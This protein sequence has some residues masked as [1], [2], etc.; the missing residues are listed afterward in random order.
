MK[1]DNILV[2]ENP[3]DKP[4]L[5]TGHKMYLI[6]SQDGL[7]PKRGAHIPHEMW[8]MWMPPAKFM[9]GFHI[10]VNGTYLDHADQFKMYP[11]GCEM[12]YQLAD[13]LIMR[14]FQWIP[15]EEKAFILELQ[16]ENTDCKDFAL[17]LDLKMITN[18]MPT[19][20]SDRMNIEAGENGI[21]VD[22][23]KNLL[24]FTTEKQSWTMCVGI[25]AE[26]SKVTCIDHHTCIASAALQVPAKGQVKMEVIFAAS[27]NSREEAEAT[28]CKVKDTKESL[29]AEKVAIYTE[30]GKKAALTYPAEP[31]LQEM[32]HWNQYIN[33]WIIR[34][35]DG[36]GAGVV[37][38]YPEFTWW[39]GNDTDYIVPALLM[40]GNY[41]IGKETLRL[42]RKKSEEINGNGRVVHEISNNGQVY[43]E[44]MSTETP[45]FADTVWMIYTWSGDVDFLT[46]MYDFCVQ[47]MEYIESI[48]VDGL[49][50]GYGIS[51]IAGLD[52]Y[53]CDCALLAVRGYEIL[54][55]MSQALGKTEAA[56]E[57]EKKQ[58]A[59]WEQFK[60]EFYMPELGFFGDMVATKEEI[61]E[62]ADTWKYTLHSF[63]ITEED[64]ILSESSCSQDKTPRDMESKA[65]LRARME[66]IMEQASALEPGE[67]RPYY[68][69][70]LNHG[71]IAV[72]FNYLGKE[73]AEKILAAAKA[74][75]ETD[76]IKV[77]PVMPIGIGRNI[78][79]LGNIKDAS[80]I[81]EKMKEVAEGFSVGMPGATNEIYPENGCF[82]QAWNSLATMWP[83]ANSL[84]GIKPRADKKNLYIS[85]CLDET[86]DGL[87]LSDLIIGGESF[88]FEYKAKEMRIVITVNSEVKENWT[89]TL[90]PACNEYELVIV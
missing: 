37:A 38:G 7:F 64:K 52:C 36:I 33:D 74:K 17:D 4:Y 73:E 59:T 23:K 82:V 46:E 20:L 11:Y 79:G 85:P 71:Y 8:G 78:V 15:Q 49:P 88:T 27:V 26:V 84:F 9:D 12:N 60:K 67:R 39:F 10:A 56:A 89:F 72:E 40:Q 80:G 51:E 1:E 83:Y 34:K 43:Y 30:L 77:E 44:G 6:G 61:L 16:F 69:F 75:R 63:P 19:W 50:T 62:R 29:F 3:T 68:L 24:Y 14:R 28:Y 81:V 32:Y 58:K 13:T 87:K 5:V 25:S 42:V 66:K 53:V 45:Q 18:L 47:G 2:V 76:S 21:S 90:D 48:M 86:M 22:D 41:E 31:K 65:K 54:K 57:Y 35:V 70:D 55:L